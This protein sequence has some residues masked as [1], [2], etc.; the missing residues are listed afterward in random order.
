MSSLKVAQQ[1]YIESQECL[2]KL[3]AQAVD[4]E[5]LVPLTGSVSLTLEILSKFQKIKCN[6]I[7]LTEC[8]NFYVN[9]GMKLGSKWHFSCRN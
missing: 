5:M 9:R 6:K 4:Q 8:S 7:F 3:D 2:T 1:K